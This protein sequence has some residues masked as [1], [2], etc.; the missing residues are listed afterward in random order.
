MKNEILL[1]EYADIYQNLIIS[2][3]QVNAVASVAQV[4]LN[5]FPENLPS[6]LSV[7][8]NQALS[9]ISQT[10]K[11]MEK[12]EG[13]EG[14]EWKI[15]FPGMEYPAVLPLLLTVL[16]HIT[17]HPK[18]EIKFTGIISSQ[19]IV[20]VL[21]YLDAFL[22]ETVRIICTLQP[23]AL[24]TQKTITWEKAIDA[25]SWE[26]LIENMIHDYVYEI[27]WKNISQRIALLSDKFGLLVNVSESDLLFLNENE[28]IRHLLVH[29]GG[30]VT[31][32]YLDKTGNK[33]L[34]VGTTIVIDSK[35]TSELS[36]IST[37][38][39][40]LIFRSVLEKYFDT[41]PENSRITVWDAGS[42]FR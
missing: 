25:G 12:K 29:A 3:N 9:H 30:K 18:A 2:L 14:A 21:A 6:D 39:A 40:G 36:H 32:T 17:A 7:L 8:Y 5:N 20:M 27:G 38:V 22:S 11:E 42:D 35:Q 24:K 28:D 26:Q 31:K 13:Y 16:S 1:K 23:L 34:I 15:E 37:K 4:V 33:D 10:Q 19:Q 41:T